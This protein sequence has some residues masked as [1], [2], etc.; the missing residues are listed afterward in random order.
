MV[1]AGTLPSRQLLLK[2][3]TLLLTAA[4]PCPKP[5]DVRT[6]QLRKAFKGGGVSGGGGLGMENRGRKKKRECLNPSSDYYGFIITV[7]C[8]LLS[9]CISQAEV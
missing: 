7:F 4:Q 2:A 9:Y 1:Q 8:Y 5:A 3:A 6:F